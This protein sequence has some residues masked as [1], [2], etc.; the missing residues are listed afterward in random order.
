M[1][2]SDPNMLTLEAV[3][4]I[5][6]NCI[7]ELATNIHRTLAM[8][9]RENSSLSLCRICFQFRNAATFSN[10][11]TVHSSCD[12]NL[13]PVIK[14]PW[15]HCRPVSSLLAVISSAYLPRRNWDTNLCERLRIDRLSHCATGQSLNAF[16]KLVFS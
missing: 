9:L 1:D 4:P 15:L 7:S 3:P 6:T 13:H 14:K 8:S 10:H 5:F 16:I 12:I 11:F 2:H